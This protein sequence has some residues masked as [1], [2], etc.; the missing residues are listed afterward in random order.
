MQGSSNCR[1]SPTAQSN[2]SPSS[3]FFSSSSSSATSLAS[4]TS[5][6]S[7]S[8]PSSGPFF[9]SC[10]SSSC[11]SAFLSSSSR[12]FFF[13][14]FHE[15]RDENTLTIDRR[16]KIYGFYNDREY[17]IGIAGA[18]LARRTILFLS[19]QRNERF[20]VLANKISI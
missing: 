5:F 16:T 8:S 2:S 12:P 20:I 3:S 11:S 13:S 18:E 15:M 1:P 9:F 10:H 6:S 19:F 17:F 7:I 4:L 14:H